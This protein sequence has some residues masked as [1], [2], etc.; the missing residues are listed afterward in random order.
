MPDK[1][2]ACPLLVQRETVLSCTVEGEKFTKTYF[3]P[4]VRDAC[5]A[6]QDG[7]CKKF[8]CDVMEAQDA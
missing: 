2:K 5:A 1:I 6:Y 4:C 7:Y 8:E 3:S